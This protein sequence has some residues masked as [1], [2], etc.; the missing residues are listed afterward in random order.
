MITQQTSHDH[1]S[2]FSCPL[3]QR[4][5]DRAVAR[6]TGESVG[7]IHSRGFVPLYPDVIDD[8]IPILDWDELD[9]QHGVGVH[10]LRHP[11][12]EDCWMS[13]ESLRTQ[14]PQGDSCPLGTS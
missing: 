7:T 3:Q 1:C 2:D 9:H 8:D 12:P 11:L 6:A 10:R 4:D 13:P 14:T 5:L